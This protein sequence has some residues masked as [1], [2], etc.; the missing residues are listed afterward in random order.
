MKRPLNLFY[1]LVNCENDTTELV[2]N[3]LSYPS[4][5]RAFLGMFLDNALIDKIGYEDIYTQ[6]TL[7][8]RS[9]PDL[10]IESPSVLVLFEVKTSDQ[11]P[12]GNQP[13]SYLEHA[14]QS[15]VTNKFVVFVVPQGYVHLASIQDEIENF[16]K[17]YP[18]C[19][20]GT[21]VITWNQVVQALQQEKGA[22]DHDPIRD[23]ME[24]LRMWYAHKNVGFC[25]EEIDR[26]YSDTKIPSMIMRLHQL[27]G[28]VKERLSKQVKIGYSTRDDEYGL[29]LRDEEHENIL[30][31][32]I[33]YE[34]WRKHAAPL[35]FGV[36]KS[37]SSCQA[38]TTRHDRNAVPVEDYY[39][40]PVD[41]SMFPTKDTVGSVDKIVTML[42][43]ELVFLTGKSS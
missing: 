1:N 40:C 7:P 31:F 15:G 26:M 20:V 16:L 14:R 34:F 29:Y 5:K 3:L 11:R 23:F 12:T 18:S 41:K 25:R 37:W 28:T 9:R 43:Q 35:C 8:D 36:D 42:T 2:C 32:G 22:I 38:F 10:V 39:V 21:K 4:F 33:W 24:L 19:G 27:I 13:R 6:K 17:E 30:W